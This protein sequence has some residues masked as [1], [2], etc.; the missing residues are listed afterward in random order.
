MVDEARTAHD[1]G[2][3]QPVVHELRDHRPPLGAL[4]LR[5][6]GAGRGTQGG[7][8]VGAEGGQPLLRLLPQLLLL[9]GVPLELGALGF[10]GFQD[11]VRIAHARTP[12]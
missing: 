6:L 12:F 11:V 8:S 7:Q 3:G 9:L 1:L 2:A 5:T 4:L 10:Y